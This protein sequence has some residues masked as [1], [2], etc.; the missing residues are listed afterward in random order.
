MRSEP[1]VGGQLPRA[2]LE[3]QFDRRLIA[4]HTELADIGRA[5][6]E[7]SDER[8][9]SGP[10]LSDAAVRAAPFQT[11]DVRA[12]VI[13]VV[14]EQ[15]ES[16]VALTP[17]FD[18]RPEMDLRLFSRPVGL[19]KRGDLLPR[20]REKLGGIADAVATLVIVPP[21]RHRLTLQ[22]ALANPERPQA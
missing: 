12:G 1:G 20:A 18:V 15:R 8:E 19:T 13:D 5:F 21:S 16:L 9:D 6:G 11:E 4:V 14:F 17:R 10:R 2:D 7:R 22:H 3:P